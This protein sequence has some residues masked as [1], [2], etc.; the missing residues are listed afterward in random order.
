MQKINYLA[1][2][3]LFVSLF[4]GIQSSYSQD[5]S[6]IRV[7]E[8]SDTQIRQFLQ[9]VEASGLS[10]A[11]LEQV[12]VSRGMPIEEVEKLRIR[13]NQLNTINPTGNIIPSIS[14]NRTIQDTSDQP[15]DIHTEA[16]KAIDQLKSKIFGA[17]LFRNANPQF[18]PNLNIATPK[19]YVIGTGDEIMIEIYGDS[20]ASYKLKVSPEGNINIPYIG[21][22]SVGGATIEAASARIKN[23]LSSIYSG[24]RNGNTQLN[25]TLSNIR[26]IKVILSGEI[27]QPGT[28]TL[29]SIATVFNALYSSGGPTENGSLRD[30]RVIRNGKQIATL[31]VYDFLMQG[32]LENNITL[33]DQDVIYVPA[34]LSR[35][36]LIGEVKRPALFETK[37][38]E[39]FQ[40]LVKYAG[41]FTEDAYQARVKV[42]KNTSIERRIEDLLASQFGQYEPQS[43]DKF[44]ISK[45]LERFENRVTINGA[46]FRSGDYELSP[47]LTLS[48]LIKKA[49]GVT[50]DAFLGRGYITRLKADNQIEQVSFNVADIIAGTETDIPLQRE[51]VIQISSIFDLK[52][53]YTVTIGGEVRQPNTFPYAENITVGTLIQM[54]GGLKVGA[55]GN[56]IEVA[57]RIQ[58]TDLTDVSAA[59]AVVFDIKI[60]E[61]LSNEDAG[62]ILEPFDVVSI[63]S[64]AGYEIQMQV[65][66]EGEVVYPGI[67]T[68]TRKDERISDLIQRAGGLTAFAYQEGAS[69][70]RPG[71]TKG[72]DKQSMLDEREE[73]NA[74]NANLQRLAEDGTA[75]IQ[76]QEIIASDLIGIDLAGILKKPHQRFDLILED[77]DVIRVPQVLQT[78]K[79]NGEVLRP[80]NIVYN[81]SGGLKYY[82]DAA[83]GFTQ[84]ARRKGTYIQ[85]ANGSVAGTTGMLFFKKYPTVKPGSEIFVPKRAPREKLSAQ[86]WV[87][88][89]SAIVSMAV[90]IFTLVK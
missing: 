17:S 68:L 59:S 25:I 46:I 55:T 39:T 14:Q 71:S 24:L 75:N 2:L 11:Q 33:Q 5:M 36:E 30:I 1:S 73:E 34:Y 3:I 69:L 47:G 88:I 58:N 62:F 79:V 23:Q 57:R 43:G 27:T 72:E 31:D 60:D 56:R 7:N 49:D 10:E 15:T 12:A 53:N 41:G 42:L 87:G 48:M 82:V 8:L 63:R 50:D 90:M 74:R 52:E 80:N 61:T 40:D 9:Q 76:L 81:K 84:E 38:G 19:N 18:Q 4:V 64:M 13:V 29:P 86:G 66:L 28:Y 65:K 78:V 16:E 85:Y 67:Y 37:P 32:S 21:I 44:T 6:N 89:S 54:A 77:G 51:D 26:S 22:V 70:K 35:V 45:I 20:E 83:G